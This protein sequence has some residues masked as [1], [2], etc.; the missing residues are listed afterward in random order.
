MMSPSAMP[1]G[2]AS[3][4]FMRATLP[5]RCLA[6][7]EVELAVQARRRLVA[8]EFRIIFLFHARKGRYSLSRYLSGRSTMTNRETMLEVIRVAYAARGRGDLDSLM[9]AFHPTAVFTLVGDKR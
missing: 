8:S 1:R 7:A 4:G 5:P 9:S 2:L 6:S 3:R